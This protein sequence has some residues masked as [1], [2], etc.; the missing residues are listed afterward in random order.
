MPMPAATN[1]NRRADDPNPGRT[2][3]TAFTR[4]RA[5]TGESDTVAADESVL[6]ALLRSRPGAAYSCRQGFCGTCRIRAT[7]GVID[8]RDGI[9][10]EPERE[11]GYFLPC[12]SRCDSD[13]LI[14]E[15]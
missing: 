1:R 3:G 11:A 4:T 13:T 7:A 9:L 6:T 10:T 5:S 8:H 2:T 12:V 15:A 14:V